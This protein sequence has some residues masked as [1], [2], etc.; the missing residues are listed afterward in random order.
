MFR[1]LF[2]R[3]LVIGPILACSNFGMSCVKLSFNNIKGYVNGFFFDKYLLVLSFKAK[4]YTCIFH[5]FY[6]SFVVPFTPE[7]VGFL[8]ITIYVISPR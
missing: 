8:L 6:S 4:S 3:T 7:G 5:L 2:V 1:I